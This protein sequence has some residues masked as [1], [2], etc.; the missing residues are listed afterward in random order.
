MYRIKKCIS[1]I[2]REIY[3]TIGI[4]VFIYDYNTLIYKNGLDYILLYIIKIYNKW[5]RLVSEGW[6]K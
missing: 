3:L 6:I 5:S 1:K 4:R 2:K